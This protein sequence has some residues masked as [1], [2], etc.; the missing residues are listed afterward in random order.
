MNTL[1]LRS[2]SPSEPARAAAITLRRPV[3]EDGAAV[4]AL[5]A[6]CDPLDRNSLYCNLL[7]CTHFADTCVVAMLGDRIVGWV[8]AHIPP[9][10]PDTLFVWQVAVA[11]EARGRALA[12][13]MIDAV[14]K[15]AACAAVAQLKTTIT[16]ENEASWRTFRR[17]AGA[18]GAP[19]ESEPWFMRHTHFDGAHATEFLVTIG[20]FAAA[21][22]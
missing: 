10:E 17:V 20:P 6:R 3:P 1:I 13:D 18:R 19:L 5:I 7:Q 12:L 4:N 11:P 21:R 15:R 9:R 2:D 16:V 8:S 14:L 22:F